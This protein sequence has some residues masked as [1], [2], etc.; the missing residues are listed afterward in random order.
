M[1]QPFSIF[2]ARKRSLRRLC[3]Y[4]CLS[5]HRGACVAGGMHGRRGMRATHA[6]PPPDTP[7]MVIRTVSRQYASYWNA[8]LSL[9]KTTRMHSSRIRTIHCSGCLL[10]GGL[11]GGV[12]PRRGVYLGDV[13][14][15]G[16]LPGGGVSAWGGHLPGGC[17]RPSPM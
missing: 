10:G 6:P 16:C 2:T 15:G 9:H 14:P 7:D 1:A 4:R 17:V 12:C 13:C 11:S 8:F 3:F 5:V